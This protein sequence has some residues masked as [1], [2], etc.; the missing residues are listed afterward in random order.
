M[1]ASDLVQHEDFISYLT[2]IAQ[3]GL[4]KAADGFGGM[5]G[6][7]PIVKD[8]S[9]KRIGIYELST[10]LD[11]PE[12]EAVG[13]YLRIEGDASGQI[14]LII[15]YQRA[16]ELADELMDQPV[17]TSQ[18]LGRLERSALAEMGNMTGSF[19]LNS[20]SDI[21]GLSA[22]PSPPAV[23]VDMLGAILDIVVATTGGFFEDLLLMRA[24]FI[25]KERQ[26]E[27][28]FWVIP[29]PV[30]LEAIAKTKKND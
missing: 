14:M 29:D 18:S 6:E 2:T 11:S 10:M 21:S 12:A 3:A 20:I 9:I 8:I 5:V 13:I 17:G 24:A 30:T 27:A 1:T 22:R 19:F 23:M 26:L 7:K 25:Y 16:L 28:D 15:P 4:N